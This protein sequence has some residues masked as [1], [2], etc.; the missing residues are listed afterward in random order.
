M[1]GVKKVAFTI[2]PSHIHAGVPQILC[3]SC[4]Y[5]FEGGSNH[6]FEV[7]AISSDTH[8]KH[9]KRCNLSIE[10]ELKEYVCFLR[11]E[12]IPCND[13]FLSVAIC[14]ITN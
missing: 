12:L 7:I 14:N 3:Y 6:V 2:S 13:T 11:L 9:V 10:P 8:P 4:Q 5:E 1:I